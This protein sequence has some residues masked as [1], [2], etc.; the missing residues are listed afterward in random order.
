MERRNYDFQELSGRLTFSPRGPNEP[1]PLTSFVG[2]TYDIYQS[3]LL[4]WMVRPPSPEHDTDRLTHVISSREV[5][6]FI[7]GGGWSLTR[8]V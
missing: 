8:L 7:T 3:D 5:K 4:F 6:F 1:Y 2:D